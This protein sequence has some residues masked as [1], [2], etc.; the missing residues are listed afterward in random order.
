[1]PVLQQTIRPRTWLLLGLIMLFGAV[2]RIASLEYAPVG[3]HGDVAWKGINALDWLDSG[4]FPYYVWELYAPEPMIVILSALA[5]PFTGVS[6]LAGRTVT[7]LFGVLFSGFLFG[8]AW[9]LMAE[10]P[11]RRRELAALLAALAAAASLHANYLSR[12]GMRA[13]IFP[14]QCALLTWLVAWAWHKGGWLRWTLAGVVLAWMQYTYIPARLFPVVLALWF[15]HGYFAD[16]PRWRAR[17]RGGLLMLAVAVLLS[18][19]NIITFIATP[20]AFTARADTGTAETGGWIWDYDTSAEGGM[21]AVLLKKV[22]LELL[23]VGVNWD[24][25]YSMMGYPMLTPLFFV[26][27]LFAVGLLIAHP[28]RIVTMWPTLAL[29]IMF[30]TDLISGAVVD[31]HGLRQTGVLPFVLL[32]AGVGLA[33]G[34]EWALSLLKAPAAR[35]VLHAVLIAL[36]VLPTLWG[37]WRYLG[38]HIPAVYAD[39]DT[40]WRTEQIDVDISRHIIARPDRAYLVPFDEYNR[41]NIAFLT[42]QVFRQRHSAVDAQG[43]LNIPA[44]PEELVIV[45]ASDPERIRHDGRLSVWDKRLWVL[46]RDDEALFLPPF[47]PAQTQAVLD[48]LAAGDPERLTDRSESEIAQF[49]SVTTPEGLFAP[50][51]VVAYP[52]QADFSLPGGGE[53]E[54]RLAGYDLPDETL[55]AGAITYITLYWQTLR[56]PSEDYEIFAQVWN[57]AG[58]AVAGAH[59]FPNGGMY[60]TRIW[61]E[62]ELTVTHHWLRLPDELPQGAYSLAAGLYR[63]LH[64]EP[65]AAAGANANAN[66][67]LALSR[68]LRVLEQVPDA[69]GAPFAHDLRFGDLLAVAALE[70]AEFTFGETWPAA[71]GESLTLDLY[72]AVLARPRLDYSLFLHLTA[73]DD[74]PPVAQADVALGARGLPSGVWYPGD[75]WH[76]SVTLVLPADLPPGEYTLWM[77]VYYYADN[78]RLNPVLDGEPQPDG[79][80]QVGHVIV[81]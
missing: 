40:G 33:A 5:M 12:L 61:R 49:Y 7:M 32:L 54:I 38:V 19:P 29:P 76:D 24:G 50:R 71:P 37:M 59:D 36:A 57:D 39:P 46:L 78:S 81:E 72:W 30:S 6:Y 41:A 21:I 70:S 42:S 18:L 14:V 47:T 10:T 1:M 75:Q 20:E 56:Q 77:G 80:V 9:W 23:A 55:S 45:T 51:Q 25:A 22:G 52:M 8:A 64:N 65:L 63:V 74:A 31:I 68:D 4:V 48:A 44:P 69:S 28:R 17:W 35:R 15:A 34:W 11:Y 27:F 3:G 67:D 26:G 73:A 16:R 79:R 53:P 43:T 66:A 60:R 62:D 2:M 13:A 58:E